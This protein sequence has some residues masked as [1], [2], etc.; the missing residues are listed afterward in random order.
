MLI[1]ALKT[2]RY[3]DYK[4]PCMFIACHSCSFKCDRDCK[5]NVC[6][7]SELAKSPDIE[8]SVA[9]MIQKYIANPITKAI[10]FGGLE[11][12]DDIYNV[13]DFI[14]QFR[15]LGFGDDIVIYTGYTKQEILDKFTMAYGELLEY[16]NI[17]IKY[18]RFIPNKAKHFDRVLG[19]YL[20]SDNQYAE[21]L[22]AQLGSSYYDIPKTIKE[23]IC[24]NTK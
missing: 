10:V 6:Q 17:V 23:K 20:S 8:I 11:P 9:E 21:R 5:R 13:L 3:Q 22:D 2:E 24:Q 18:G 4:Y 14:K 7:N 19:V 15:G 16:V 12:F 1:K